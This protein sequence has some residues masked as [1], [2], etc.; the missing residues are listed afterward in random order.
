M[1]HFL[2]ILFIILSGLQVDAKK[3]NYK[4]NVQDFC[5]LTVVDGVHVEYISRVDSTGWAVFECEEELASKIMFTNNVQRLTIQTAADEEPIAGM[6][7]VKVYSTTLRRIENSGDSVLTVYL[8]VPV[9]HLSIIQIDNGTIVAN[10]I[11][12]ED[13]TVNLAAG[14]GHIAINGK[15]KKSKFTNV[16]GGHIDAEKL[17]TP[18]ARCYVFGKGDIFVSP[19]EQLKIYGAGSG[20]IYYTAEPK[21]K[22]S[23]GI[24]VKALKKE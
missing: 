1:K 7:L 21:K 23:R 15:A 19:R 4:L 14:K 8:N 6:P 3:S 18:L 9:E 10:N 17:E 2:L 22:T 13:L 5:E 24:G 16:S 12:A 20:K 11:E